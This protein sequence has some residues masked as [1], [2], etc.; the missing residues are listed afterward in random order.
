MFKK[1]HLAVALTLA[2]LMLL[3]TAILANK[4]DLKPEFPAPDQ[5]G[6]CQEYCGPVIE[7]ARLGTFEAELRGTLTA[8]AGREYNDN[9]RKAVPIVVMGSA[10]RG[11]VEGLGETMIWLDK[12]R[13]LTGSFL[14]ENKA[15]TNFPA[16]QVMRSHLLLRTDAL[17]GQTFRSIGPFTVES[18]GMKYWP[19]QDAEFVLVEPVEFEDINAPGEVVVRLL[20]GEAVVGSS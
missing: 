9:G 17:P 13:P 1:T 5:S 16:T 4:G 15:G 6:D 11:Y 7:V 18:Q 2:T 3:S 12:S 19:P 8:R 20:S 14:R 10:M